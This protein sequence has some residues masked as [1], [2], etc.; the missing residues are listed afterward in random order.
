MCVHWNTRFV[1]VAPVKQS[2]ILALASRGSRAEAG[3]SSNGGAMIVIDGSGSV[4]RE[5]EI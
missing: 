3:T 1:L 2:G 4:A 5:I